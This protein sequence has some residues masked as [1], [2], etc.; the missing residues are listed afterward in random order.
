MNNSSEL[1]Q[2]GDTNRLRILIKNDML[3]LCVCFLSSMNSASVIISPFAYR[4]HGFDK[5]RIIDASVLPT[6]V[7]GNPNSILVGMALRG[8]ARVLKDHL[9]DAEDE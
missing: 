7:S 5:I 6:P 3:N 9:N 4:V 1:T 8:A 2:G